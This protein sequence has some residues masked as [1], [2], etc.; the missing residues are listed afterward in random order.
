M[1]RPGAQRTDS[2]QSSR[3]LLLSAKAHVDTKPQL[4]I[5]A[6]DV[7]CAHGATVGQLDSDE[8]FYLQEPR[9]VRDGGAQSADL[10]IRR[11]DHR[12]HPRRVAAAAARADRARTDRRRP[13]MNAQPDS[14]SNRDATRRRFDVERIRAD[15]PI[16]K[17][18]VDGKP[19][20]YLDN[21]ASSQMPQPVIDRL[22][23]YQTREHANIHRAVHYLSETA[24]AEYEEARRKLQR[25]I[26][27][28]EDARGHL[29]QRHHRR[30]QPGDARLR[31]QVH[32]R[33]RRNH[34]DHARASFEHRALADAGAKRR[35]RRSAWCRSTTPANCCST[36]TRSCSTTR[37]KFVGVTHVSNA[38]GTHQPGQGDDRLCACAR[39]AGAGRRR[40]G[41]A[42]PDG[43]RAGSRLRLLRL[44]GPQAVRP[45]R[46]RHA[47]RQGRAARSA[48]SR[49][50][51][52]AT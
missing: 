30:D 45:D 31:P 52:A 43:R 33:R 12:S 15:F 37:T 9:P 23:R 13:A 28:R 42:A 25:F 4:E 17:L 36:N 26:N 48:C 50:R 18:K 1:V 5:F 24:T 29:H 8:V 22:V 3:N 14:P 19:L 6:D 2:A 40:A 49:S 47:L 51:A 11:R 41:G 34:P 21:A 27:A 46:H 39:R 32:R 35:A 10:C 44:L 38:L 16:L 20:V 7:K